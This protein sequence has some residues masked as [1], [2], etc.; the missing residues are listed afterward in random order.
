MPNWFDEFIQ[1]SITVG[2]GGGGDVTPPTMGVTSPTVNTAPGVG[3]GFSAAYTTAKDTP[4][5]LTVVDA[6]SAI[7]LVT[8]VVQY[9]GRTT[10]EAI[11]IGRPGIDFGLGFLD[12]Y[13]LNST[14]TGSGAPGVGY[15]FTL[16]N[17]TG[18]PGRPEVVSTIR[19]DT[20]AVD[21]G[22]NVLP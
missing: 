8:M 10:W 21:A 1:D 3:A 14:V 20:K 2:G 5:V 22:G 17:D 4:I 13:K 9:E 6:A 19:I 15:T 11:Y 16:R 7:R 18:W 12:G